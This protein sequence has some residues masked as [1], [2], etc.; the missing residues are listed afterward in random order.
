MQRPAAGRPHDEVLPRIR[1]AGGHVEQRR[2]EAGAQARASTGARNENS[3]LFSLEALIQKNTLERP[4][5][6]ARKDEAA[7]LL[8]PPN[9]GQR[10]RP[11]ADLVNVG[12]GGLMNA[13]MSAPTYAPQTP[14]PAAA[15]TLDAELAEM[16]RSRRSGAGWW[17]LLVL[18]VLGGIAAAVYVLRPDLLRQVGVLPQ[19]SPKSDP[20]AAGTEAGE[21]E[22]IPAAPDEPEVGDP[23]EAPDENTSADPGENPAP[24]RAPAPNPTSGTRNDGPG[25][26]S[27]DRAEA[28]ERS[29]EAALAPFDRDA[30][31]RALNEAASSLGAC[32]QA[33]ER[34]GEGRAQVTFAPS[35]RVTMA[36]IT[37][38]LAGSAVGGCV[39][40]VF[41]SA[42]VPP[43]Q[44]EATTVSKSFSLE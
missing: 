8:G 12:A 10:P 4:D 11:P 38:D 27:Q 14:S 32:R 34:S 31:A 29:N 37:G 6:P 24:S 40:R 3:V 5:L 16:Y 15:A 43:F 2:A 9:P 23:T 17:A 39:A 26:A 35:G 41:R 7:L 33:G 20:A 42:R 22:T 18:L 30:A 19:A 13:V 1:G 36:S 28:A 44:G 21:P 25:Q